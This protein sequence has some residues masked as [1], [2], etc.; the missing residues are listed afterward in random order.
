M[1]KLLLTVF[2]VLTALS[3]TS[4]DKCECATFF[5]D[6]VKDEH[7]VYA[8]PDTPT[9]DCADPQPCKK[10]CETTFR[11]LTNDG[12]LKHVTSRNMTVGE[13][14]CK[15]YRRDKKDGI[16]GAFVR[17]CGGDWISAVN[18]AEK[19]SCKGGTIVH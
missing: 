18:L 17:N 19:L 12:N 11:K 6:D 8:V 7:K 1:A 2:A 3:Y 13:L 9:A 4:A 15:M 16:L 5:I 10:S 14:A